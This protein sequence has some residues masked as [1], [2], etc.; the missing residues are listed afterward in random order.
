MSSSETGT[1]RELKLTEYEYEQV[2]QTKNERAFCFCDELL[3]TGRVPGR[4]ARAWR[5]VAVAACRALRLR[6]LKFKLSVHIYKITRRHY[7]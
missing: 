4:E 6:D 3:C 1:G 5:G 2:Y 7:I